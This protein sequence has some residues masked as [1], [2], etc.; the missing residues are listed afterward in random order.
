MIGQAVD[1]AAKCGSGGLTGDRIDGAADC[2]IDDVV[3]G[4]SDRMDEAVTAGPGSASKGRFDGATASGTG[5]WADDAETATD[6]AAMT[7][8]KERAG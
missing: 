7:A 1:D 5:A 6:A 8:T 2:G 3:V 4:G